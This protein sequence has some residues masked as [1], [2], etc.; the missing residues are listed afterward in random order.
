M[1]SRVL[2][3]DD[4]RT[5]CT[6]LKTEFESDGAQVDIAEDGCTA[7]ELYKLH[8]YDLVV[9]DINMPRMDGLQVL[10]RIKQ[11]DKNTVVIIMTAY[12]SIDGAVSAMKMQADDY[13]TKPFDP[14]DLIEKF[15]QIQAV[16]HKTAHLERER[17]RSIPML[18]GQSPA[19]ERVR[20]KINKVKD[21]NTTVLITGESG[22]GKGV[23]AKNI[24]YTSNRAKLPFSHIDCASLP[25]NLIE[26]ELF[27]HEKGAFTNASTQRKGKLELAGKG[28]IFLDEISTLSPELQSKLLI[29]LQERQFE[30][31]GGT[32]R[33][34]VDARVIAATNED[35]E[36]AVANGTFRADL[37]YRLNIVCIELPPLRYRRSDIP[38]LAKHFIEQHVKN[39]GSSLETVDDAVWDALCEY[40]WPGNVRELENTLESAVI[41]SDGHR[42]TVDDLPKKITAV[43]RKLQ[44]EGIQSGSDSLSLERQEILTILAALDKH[45]GHRE[46]TAKELGIS[47]R[48][49]Q[50][51]LAKYH[52]TK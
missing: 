4:E 25:H 32:Q 17:D 39:T 10:K 50:Y 21:L 11:N 20:A 9:L 37:F 15:R 33:L 3:A 14:P 19:M 18:L 52:I 48:T 38:E 40:D 42:L 41:L 46:K 47:R 31:L 36:T 16:K 30:R 51:K 35:L 12:G 43:R 23:V 49:L 5:I 24:H 44:P 26:S 2:I 45:N 28:T 8:V 29:V 6:I 22:T 13:I 27:G 1:K 7:W 34:S